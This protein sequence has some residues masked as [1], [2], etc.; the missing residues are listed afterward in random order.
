MK[1]Q[2]VRLPETE[3]ITYL[4]LDDDYR[5]IEPILSY[6]KFLHDLDRSPNTIRACAHHLKLFW[7]YLRDTRSD[8]TEVDI[9]QLAA[10]ISWLRRPEPAVV[11]LEP[12]QARRTNASIDQM[13]GSVHGLYDFHMRMETIPEL[14]LYRFLMLPNRRYKPFLHGIAKSKPV[15]IRIVSVKREKRHAKTLTRDEVQT[16]LEACTHIRDRFLLTLMYDTGM[17]IGQVLGLRHEDINVEDGEIHIVPRDNNANGARAKTRESYTIPGLLPLMQLYTDY[18][19]KDLGAL[20]VEALPDYVFVNLWEGDIGRPMTYAAVRSL[21][22][23]LSR[24]T[25]IPFTPHML[26]H[27]RATSWIRDDKH[28]LA[29]VSRLLGHASVETTDET[30]VTL[31]PQDLKRALTEGKESDDER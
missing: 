1:V 6:L 13:L 2:R 8:W 30:Y 16:L 5:P 28:S 19:I 31:T 4:V 7:E 21:V 29:T 27:T 12:Q 25:G 14:P 17:R 20:E 3:R 18:L 23:R 24:K 10:F 11:S 22:R 15:Q 26:R 9:A